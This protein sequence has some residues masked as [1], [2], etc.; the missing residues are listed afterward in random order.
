MIRRCGC[1]CKDHVDVYC[2]FV[3]SSKCQPRQ[4]L[5]VNIA[6]LPPNCFIDIVLTPTSLTET[7]GNVVN[8]TCQTN[9]TQ[10][11]WTVDSGPVNTNSDISVYTTNTSNGILSVLTIRAVPIKVGNDVISIGC[12]LTAPVIIIK[13]AT[14]TIKGTISH[15]NYIHTSNRY[16][17][18]R[19]SDHI[20]KFK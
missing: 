9:G 18:C 13:S 3:V 16:I 20:F 12:I 15:Y 6:W 5:Y 4:Q 1:L 19:G 8:F 11:V 17:S 14:L 2:S 7:Y 10:L